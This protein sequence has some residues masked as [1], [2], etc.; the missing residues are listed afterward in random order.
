MIVCVNCGQMN[1]TAA[2]RC[3]RC[4][5]SIFELPSY[6]NPSDARPVSPPPTDPP[7]RIQVPPPSQVAPAAPPPAHTPQPTD[8]LSQP[9][10]ATPPVV[11]QP[12]LIVPTVGVGGSVICPH[13]QT[14]SPP[15]MRS[16]VAPGGWITMAILLLLC[17]PLFWIGLLVRE[18]YLRCSN[19]GKRL[20]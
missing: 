17:W 18:D 1:E 7:T 6:L 5:A 19:C 10:Q 2:S 9:F 16:R 20:T 4:G 8:P 14:N 15:H 13:C 3:L 12:M 11:L